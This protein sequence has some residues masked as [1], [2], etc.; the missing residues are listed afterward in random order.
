MNIVLCHC[1]SATELLTKKLS[2]F[3]HISGVMLE[4]LNLT[5]DFPATSLELVHCNFAIRFVKFDTFFL[6][7]GVVGFTFFFLFGVFLAVELGEEGRVGA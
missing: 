3:F 6:L 2:K 5:H 7:W 1:S 4:T